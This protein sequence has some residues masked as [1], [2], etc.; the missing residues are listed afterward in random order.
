MTTL[1]AL[2]FNVAAGSAL[3]LASLFG[4][5]VAVVNQHE[6]IAP[7]CAARPPTVIYNTS[8]GSPLLGW[9]P[10]TLRQSY[11]TL[12][13]GIPGTGT[14]Q[15]GHTGSLLRCN[16]DAIVLLRF[17]AVGLKVSAV[18]TLLCLGLL[19]P[20]YWTS[21][22]HD[23]QSGG[24]DANTEDPDSTTTNWRYDACAF[25]TNNLTGYEQTTIAN[26]PSY[27]PDEPEELLDDGTALYHQDQTLIRL[28]AAVF[29]LW[30]LTAY[31]L[32]LLKREWIEL[33]ALRRVY[34]LE[35]NVWGERKQQLQ[36]TLRQR[37]SQFQQRGPIPRP[38]SLPEC[39][40]LLRDDTEEDNDHSKRFKKGQVTIVQPENDLTQENTD[41]IYSQHTGGERGLFRRRRRHPN[42]RRRRRLLGHQPFN[43][44]EDDNMYDVEERHLMDRDPWIPH[45]E[46]RDTVSNIQLYSVL[47]GGLPSLPDF[48]NASATTTT[49]N[50]S[51]AESNLTPDHTTNNNSNYMMDWQL[52]LTSA[53]FDHCVPNQP[54]FSSSVAAVTLLP[55]SKA[56]ATA[57]SK[58]YKAASKLRR[59]KFIRAQIAKKL[60]YDEHV[61][62]EDEFDLED[63]NEDDEEEAL[64]DEYSSPSRVDGSEHEA[65]RHSTT[66]SSRVGRRLRNRLGMAGGGARSSPLDARSLG[67][68]DGGSLAGTDDNSTLGAFLPAADLP[69]SIHNHHHQHHT[70]NKN[71]KNPDDDEESALRDPSLVPYAYYHNDPEE[72]G[73]LEVAAA[74]NTEQQQQQEEE[75]LQALL[76]HPF[77]PEQTAIYSREVAQSAA[78]CCPNG[79]WEGAVLHATIDELLVLEREAA[80]N[81]HKANLELYRAR[82]EAVWHSAQPPPPPPPTTN[83]TSHSPPHMSSSS[84]GPILTTT[85]N[86]QTVVPAPTRAAADDSSADAAPSRPFCATGVPTTIQTDSMEMMTPAEPTENTNNLDSTLD[87][88]LGGQEHA[89]SPKETISIKGLATMPPLNSSSNVPPSSRVG[90]PLQRVAEESSFAT[91]DVESI[92]QSQTHESTKSLQSCSKQLTTTKKATATT[93]TTSTTTTPPPLL[94]ED[95]AT[96]AWEFF[97]PPNLE[98]SSMFTSMYESAT[99]LNSNSQQQQPV[100]PPA[101]VERARSAPTAAMTRERLPSDLA[102]EGDLLFPSH[103]NVPPP[104]SPFS[105]HHRS[106]SMPTRH[107]QSM[108]GV[109]PPPESSSSFA[110][111]ETEAPQM[112]PLQT[113][114]SMDTPKTKTHSGTS[115]MT[116]PTKKVDPDLGPIQRSGSSSTADSASLDDQDNSKDKE[117]PNNEVYA[118]GNYVSW[119]YQHGTTTAEA[120]PPARTNTE[121]TKWEKV[122]SIVAS[123]RA[124]MYSSRRRRLRSSSKRT[125]AP[126]HHTPISGVWH[127]RPSISD[128]MQA[129]YSRAKALSRFL[130]KQTTEAMDLSRES[131]YAV[132]T[133]TSR[134]AA[135]AARKCLAD[136]RGGT[137]RW[138]TDRELPIP[139]LADAAAWDLCVC[140]NCCRPVAI[141]IDTRQKTWRHYFSL[142]LLAAFYALATFP[143]TIVASL[144]DPQT[145]ERAFPNFFEW[146][147][148]S[149]SFV[150][151]DL[152]DNGPI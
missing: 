43:D 31:L 129:A 25:E 87:T 111:E 128:L 105:G 18:A 71:H 37:P 96:A 50:G 34:Y 114:S 101:M 132:V 108:W 97:K 74:T 66:S 116:L 14:R 119:G 58:W 95:F 68:A 138:K 79:C 117:Y 109:P 151:L 30:I 103:S 94:P 4:F 146:A 125:D 12:L 61:P 13:Q 123:T 99:S 35:A 65:S 60:H 130:T 133:F 131:S 21:E 144:M 40:S 100:E 104:P 135:L 27:L 134:Q 47:V 120:P 55:S 143:L 53:F 42:R 52:A 126:S 20:L 59:L 77:G 44:D 145:L 32:N 63:D 23:V 112:P 122:Q 64:D 152:P 107:P 62:E 9:I 33:L 91:L 3:G 16:L 115:P 93:T 11:E 2:A 26:V 150:S 8:H 1:Q 17:H 85:T 89:A 83:T 148:V 106:G 48:R 39:D 76:E 15:G 136:A 149:T 121:K 80:E 137:E 7:R 70:T 84:P 51:P 102:L 141:S 78:A 28:Y 29:T 86:S 90:H 92:Q 67:M 56:I 81:V 98:F 49:S 75:L 24:S 88:V 147:D 36:E 41:E 54:G 6:Y 46:Q 57:W 127:G 118:P 19:F 5:G 38:E 110:L 45:P 72:L 10:W 82:Q 142:L 69:P 113:N 140:R 73:P 139:P 22:C 124:A